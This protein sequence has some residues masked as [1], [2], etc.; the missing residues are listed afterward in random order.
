M[1][2]QIDELGLQHCDDDI[3]KAILNLPRNL[4]ETFDRAV[5]RIVSRGE[6]STATA[7]QVFRWVAASKEPLSLD[8]LREVIFIE[9]GQQFSMPERHSNGIYN[10]SSWCENL[11]YVDEELQTVQFAHQSVR[12]FFLEKASKARHNQ[13][14]LKLEYADHHIGEI[15]VTYLN[16]NDFKTTLARR[17]RPMPSMPPTAIASTALRP[18]WKAAVSSIPTLWKSSLDSRVGSATASAVE[19]LASFQ[20]TDTRETKERLQVAYPFLKYASTHCILHTT[21]FQKDKSKT[22]TL[23]ERMIVQGHD[24]MEKVWGEATFNEQSSFLLDWSIKNRHYALIRLTFLMGKISI[25]DRGHML[26]NAAIEGDVMMLDIV[27]KG[28]IPES[29]IDKACIEAIAGGRLEIVERFL[30]TDANISGVYTQNTLRVAARRG[31]LDIILKLLAG[32]GHVNAAPD[33]VYD[34]TVLQAAAECGRLEVIERLLAA[35][36]DVSVPAINEHYRTP[37][38]VAAECGRL[39]I[40]EVLLAAGADVDASPKASYGRTALQA[41]AEY[42]HMDIIEKLLAAGANVNSIPAWQY[43]RTALQAAAKNGRMDIVERLLAAGAEADEP[44][45]QHGQT[46]LQA[47]VLNGHLDIES[48]LMQAGAKS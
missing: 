44:H 31:R 1:A 13:F 26:I 8:Q 24:L 41:A 22:W 4:E 9:I 17:Q 14:H 3:R 29:E 33:I 34:Q 7:Q 15:C 36:A 27:L 40:V 18:Q 45:G 19:A 23:W 37:L 46:A 38:Q 12:Q 43:G 21:R 28:E 42:G 20:R 25:E 32:W 2:F 47:A 39:D 35:G 11:V 5:G 6:K 48:R 10:I 16:F 30:A